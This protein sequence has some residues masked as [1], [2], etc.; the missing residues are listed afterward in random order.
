MHPPDVFYYAGTGQPC[1]LVVPA[2]GEP[3]LLARRTLAWVKADSSLANIVKGDGIDD[4]RAA[5]QSAGVLQQGVKLGL[6]LDIVPTR[7]CRKLEQNLPECLIDDVSPLILAQRLLKDEAEIADIRAAAGLFQRAHEVMLRQL[8]P[9]ITELE[10]ASH[11]YGALRRGG[12]EGLCRFRRWDAT[13]PPD[14]IIVS[15]K[16]TWQISGHAMTVTGVGLSPSLPWGPSTTPVEAGDTVVID[17]GLNYHGYHADIAR[18][19]IMGKATSEQKRVFDVVK[20]VYTA[21]FAQ[22]KPGVTG[23]ALFRTAWGILESHGLEGYFQGY[24]EMKG[25]YV[26]HGLG[27]EMDEPP[28]LDGNCATKLSRNMVIAIEPKV[29]IPGWGAIDLEDTAVVTEYGCDI[30]GSVPREL[31]EVT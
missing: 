15:G 8:R 27:L 24:G 13:L 12:Y 3:V 9:G 16:N 26:G 6:T 28:V 7:L 18:T 14:G 30:L 22:V 19:Y 4:I 2:R 29:I 20:E 17:L 23:R 10:L 11:V 5:L 21:V 31:F 25:Y 1:N